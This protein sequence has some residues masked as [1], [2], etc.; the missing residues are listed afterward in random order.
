[1]PFL[2]L[3]V[4]ISAAIAAFVPMGFLPRLLPNQPGLAVPVAAV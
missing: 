3:G 1:M 2:V 4:S